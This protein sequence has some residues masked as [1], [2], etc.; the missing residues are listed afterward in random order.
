[1]IICNLLIITNKETVLFRLG[2][3]STTVYVRVKCTNLTCALLMDFEPM[4]AVLSK[5]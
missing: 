5:A 3:N 2:F 1:M 4:A